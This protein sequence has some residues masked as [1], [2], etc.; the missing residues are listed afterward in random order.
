MFT[1][2]SNGQKSRRGLF[3]AS[4]IML[5]AFAVFAVAQFIVPSSRKLI[6]VTGNEHANSL[7]SLS[8]EASYASEAAYE[9]RRG[10]WSVNISSTDSLDGFRTGE[11][12]AKNSPDLRD[13]SNYQYRQGEW[14]LP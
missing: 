10:E 6:P 7:P 11:R 1:V 2:F 4:G 5:T 9:F 3:I 8:E 13:F 12:N 14:M